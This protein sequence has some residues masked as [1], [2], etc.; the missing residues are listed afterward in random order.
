LGIEGAAHEEAA[1][2]GELAAGRDRA[3]GATPLVVSR[4]ACSLVGK[5]QPVQVAPGTCAAEAYG[6]ASVVEAFR[7]S[8]GLNPAYRHLLDGGPLVVSGLGPEGEARVIELPDHRF[9][10]AT[11][12]LPQLSSTP[13]AP[14]PL[15]RAYLA[16]GMA[17]RA[18]HRGR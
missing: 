15:V 11:L 12:Y 6:S 2:H 14:H 3:L 4:L 9:Y 17:Y 1:T 7:C 16:A 8:Y 18:R 10:V 13:G 5:R